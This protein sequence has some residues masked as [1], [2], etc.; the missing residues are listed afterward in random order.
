M[1]MLKQITALLILPL[2]L[3]QGAGSKTDNATPYAVQEAY[4]VYSAI[5]PSEW[6]LRLAHAKTLII[7]TETKG[8]EMCLRPEKEWEEKIGPAISEYVRLN[9]K[10]SLL[11]QRMNIEVSYQLIKADE[12]KSLIQR[13]GWEG[14]YQQYKHSGGW[15]ELSAVGFNNDKT[16]AV[17]YM[18]HHCGPLCGGGGFHVL[19]RKAGKWVPL[20]WQGSSCA[21]AS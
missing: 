18:G 5:L 15:I 14:F 9:A 11:E 7:Q 20:D 10:P 8:F 12:L 17:V 6:P 4:D 16:V 2:L 1:E 21:W 19:E 13:A 3:Y